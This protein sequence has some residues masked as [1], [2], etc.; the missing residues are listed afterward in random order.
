MWKTEQ[1]D[2]ATR[3]IDTA[4]TAEM[5][6]LLQR[7]NEQA[8]AAVGAVSA[9][10]AAAIDAVAGRMVQGGRLFY[11]GCG[12]SGRL[13][14]LDASECPPTFGVAPSLVQGL[15]A[16]GD[17]ALRCAVEGAEDDAAAGAADLAAC[18][19]NRLD[20][21]V[22]LSAAGG[23]RYVLGALRQAGQAGCL[24]VAVTCNRDSAL[25]GLA[26]LAIC[27]D[28]GAEPI[29]GSTRMKAG[30]AQKMIL[31]MLSTGVMIRLGKVMENLMVNVQPTNEK[32]RG[33]C[34][35]I[36]QELAPCTAQQAQEALLKANWDIRRAVETLGGSAH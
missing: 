22:G 7:A 25:A 2:P 30:T 18:Q 31:N 28:T 29:T 5:V 9:E 19:P 24:T 33:R 14:V 3:H 15:I 4:P 13:G 23:A 32:L 35:R 12:T 26:Q 10:I 1:R 21:V 17:R 6:A 11:V 16:G 20:T 34:I 8:A 36:V 27:P